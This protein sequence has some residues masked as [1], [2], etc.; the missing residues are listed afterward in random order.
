MRKSAVVERLIGAFLLA[1]FVLLV[2]PRIKTASFFG[3]AFMFLL[4]GAIAWA[5]GRFFSGEGDRKYLVLAAVIIALALV[6]Y[7]LTPLFG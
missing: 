6:L 4:I 7:F 5:F 1:G 2:L 3:V